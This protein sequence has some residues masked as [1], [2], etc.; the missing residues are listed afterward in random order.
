ML[1]YAN[2]TWIPPG[3]IFILLKPSFVN[4]KVP[5]YIC[6]SDSSTQ[7]I[8]I[9]LRY[10]KWMRMYTTQRSRSA[11][12][13]IEVANTGEAEQIRNRAKVPMEVDFIVKREPQNDKDK[14]IKIKKGNGIQK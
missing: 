9:I 4:L 3:N 5:S 2:L 7:H 8:V 1:M 10:I 13:L 14:K 12:D 6:P 11:K